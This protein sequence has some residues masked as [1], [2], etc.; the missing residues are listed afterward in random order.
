MFTHGPTP[1]QTEGWDGQVG[2]P[3]FGPSFGP[4]DRWVTSIWDA[5]P[6]PG[7]MVGGANKLNGL[8]PWIQPMVERQVPSFLRLKKVDGSG[9]RPGVVCLDH[10]LD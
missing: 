3:S 6:V 2:K 9:I 5:G 4:W 8:D 7:P 1:G 10:T